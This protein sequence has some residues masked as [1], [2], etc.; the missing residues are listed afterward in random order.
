MSGVSFSD[1]RQCVFAFE[2]AA[3]GDVSVTVASA[4]A[5]GLDSSDS[6]S[7]S[8]DSSEP[9]GELLGSA[10]GSLERKNST[11]MTSE[12]AAVLLDQ[13]TTWD[14]K[15]ALPHGIAAIRKHLDET[16]DVPLQARPTQELQSTTKFPPSA[17]ARD[18]W[19]SYST[20]C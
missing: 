16:D 6:D 5:A 18:R 9:T 4:V 10:A 20:D 19:I 12:D 15:A 13:I 17:I 2:S 1:D 3:Q 11:T 7:D 14:I 8:D